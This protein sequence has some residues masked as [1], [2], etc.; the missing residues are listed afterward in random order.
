MS[1]TG[2]TTT[3]IVSGLHY[4]LRYRARNEIGFGDYS[5]IAY[6][7]TASAPNNPTIMSVTIVGTDVII[8]WSMPYNSGS[9]IKTAE[10]QIL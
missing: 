10:I 5:D 7:L 8:S 4:R 3:N 6:I 2:I 9:L 1:L